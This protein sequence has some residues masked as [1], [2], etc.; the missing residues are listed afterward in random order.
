MPYSRALPS[1]PVEAPLWRSLTELSAP[2]S[3]AELQRATA[4][5]P[6]AIMHRL[7]R[8][9]RA[10]L[11]NR[12]EGEPLRYTMNDNAPRTPA[13]PRVT[14]DGTVKS[15]PA[16]TTRDRLWRSMR[17]LRS[18]DLPA[19][20]MAAEA[21]RRSAE[22]LVNCLC[23]AGYL[24]MTSRGQSMRGTWSTYRL[25]RN[26]G[27]RAPSVTQRMVEGQRLRELVDRNTGDRTDISPAATSLRR[28]SKP[29][30]DGGVS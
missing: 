20:M 27:P 30:E 19:L 17:V 26:T 6:N 1:G 25:I 7:H 10:G 23:R 15:R 24:R 14:I 11:V 5:H 22:D 12:I 3:V 29:V 8:W 16:N 13:P 4:A 21:S 28:L 18:F 2:A 9:V